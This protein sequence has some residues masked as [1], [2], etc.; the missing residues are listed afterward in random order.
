LAVW[1]KSQ[2]VE[3]EAHV[4]HTINLELNY[5]DKNDEWQKTTQLREGD[6]G[7]ANALLERAQ[8]RLMK[9]GEA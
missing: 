3:S 5:K 1:A 8:F 2:E 7:S 6:L 9:S 4:F